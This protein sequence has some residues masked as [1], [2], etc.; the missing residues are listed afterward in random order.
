MAETSPTTPTSKLAGDDSPL[1]KGEDGA[2]LTVMKAIR[3]SKKEAFRA[4]RGRLARNRENRRAYLG[5]QDF[6]H[7]QRASL[8]SSYPRRLLL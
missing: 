3:E 7:K 4:R 8:R 6:S 5:Y 2:A 1:G